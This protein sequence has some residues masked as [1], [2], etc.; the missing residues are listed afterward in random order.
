MAFWFVTYNG[1]NGEIHSC[2]A[3]DGAFDEETLTREFD[4]SGPP[5]WTPSYIPLEIDETTYNTVSANPE[6]YKVDF[7]DTETLPSVVPV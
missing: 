5:N 7:G 2:E 3:R 6:G 1:H 4:T